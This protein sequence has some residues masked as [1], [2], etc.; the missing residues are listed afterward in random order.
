MGVCAL[1][2]RSSLEVRGVVGAVHSQL[3]FSKET[4]PTRAGSPTVRGTVP[5]HSA[6]PP[7]S[8]HRAPHREAHPQGPWARPGLV[9]DA[10]GVEVGLGEECGVCGQL[11]FPHGPAP[12]RRRRGEEGACVQW[13]C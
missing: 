3:A 7:C 2:P 12:G 5:G 4:G 9:L 10:G 13:L 8:S 6:C 11:F 1:K